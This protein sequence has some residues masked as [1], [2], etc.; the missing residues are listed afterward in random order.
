MQI[1]SSGVEP[2]QCLTMGNF[3]PGVRDSAATSLGPGTSMRTHLRHVKFVAIRDDKDTR[4]VR[5]DT[6]PSGSG[7]REG[8]LAAAP[9]DTLRA[10]SAPQIGRRGSV[11]KPICLSTDAWSQ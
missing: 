9:A 8:G 11:S 4:N 6:P 3:R 2:I 7:Y 5:D 1:D 10:G